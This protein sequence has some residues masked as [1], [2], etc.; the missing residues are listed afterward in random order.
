VA[1]RIND[2]LSGRGEITK[3]LPQIAS[4]AAAETTFAFCGRLYKR[5]RL[6]QSVA[7]T[8][9][10]TMSDN[11][12]RLIV[13]SVLALLITFPMSMILI[14]EFQSGSRLQ[15]GLD[16]VLAVVGIYALA[17]GGVCI[18]FWDWPISRSQSK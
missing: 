5:A 8:E 7:V 2:T 3:L 17:L 13:L 1:P 4:Q 18:A 11:F 14:P 12:R 15:I 16:Q 6:S 9:E 10:P